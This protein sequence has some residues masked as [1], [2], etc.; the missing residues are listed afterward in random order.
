M[1]L[2]LNSLAVLILLTAGLAPSLAQNIPT[3]SLAFTLIALAVVMGVGLGFWWFICL[4]KISSASQRPLDPNDVID[5]YLNSDFL[6]LQI[7]RPR[8]KDF[9]LMRDKVTSLMRAAHSRFMTSQVFFLNFLPGIFIFLTLKDDRPSEKFFV[10][11]MQTSL[12]KSLTL[13]ACMYC[14]ISITSIY[15]LGFFAKCSGGDK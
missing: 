3:H 1:P 13:A 7:A 8:R 12:G 9:L 6:W 15:S 5:D 11:L 2:V 10:M 14:V 4:S